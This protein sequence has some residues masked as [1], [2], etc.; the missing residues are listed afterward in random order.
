MEN[1]LKESSEDLVSLLRISSE[2]IKPDAKINSS[3]RSFFAVPDGFPTNDDFNRTI[4]TFISAAEEWNKINFGVT[5]LRTTDRRT[6]NFLLTFQAKQNANHKSSHVASAFIG[7]HKVKSVVIY[8]LA[9]TSKSERDDLRIALL[10]E[11]G[12]VLGLRHE[13]EIKPDTGKPPNGPA[14]QILA[15][16][17]NSVMNGEKR[18]TIQQSDIIAIKEFY[19]KPDGWVL[20]GSTVKIRDFEATPLPVKKP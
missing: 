8:G 2:V 18:N 1:Q 7:P 9:L 15:P 12:H 6:A 11:I 14:L 20:P 4:T 3:D 19:A 10:H 16:N 17:P 5:L 13:I